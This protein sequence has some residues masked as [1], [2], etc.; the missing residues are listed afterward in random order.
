MNG[1]KIIEK[2]VSERVWGPNDTY[3]V[4]PE[5]QVMKVDGF[6]KGDRVKVTI[7][8][9]TR[10]DPIIP[11]KSLRRCLTERSRLFDTTAREK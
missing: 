9:I 5:T 7:E 10:R 6:N 2:T 1:K 3:L 8:K 4:V 11:D